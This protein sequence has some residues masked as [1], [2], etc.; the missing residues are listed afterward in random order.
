MRQHEVDAAAP[1]QPVVAPAA[2]EVVEVVQPGSVISRGVAG[3][4]EKEMTGA[5]VAEMVAAAVVE[6]AAL[7]QIP[8]LPTEEMEGPTSPTST[9]PGPAPIP[10]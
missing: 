7:A 6:R 9:P 4:Q 10:V 5:M 3:P 2:Q 8:P 1:D